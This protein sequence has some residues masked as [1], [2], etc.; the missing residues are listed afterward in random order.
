MMYICWGRE[1]FCDDR[2]RNME[3]VVRFRMKVLVDV[4]NN[5]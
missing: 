2:A 3:R 1:T 5:C 4:G